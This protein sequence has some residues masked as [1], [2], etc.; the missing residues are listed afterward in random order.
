M[1]AL[2]KVKKTQLEMVR[3]RGYDISAEE[4]ILSMGPRTFIDTYMAKVGDR[5]TIRD[6][7]SN[8]YSHKNGKDRLYVHFA[9]SDPKAK[10]SLGNEPVR[11]FLSLYRDKAATTAILISELTPTSNAFF[12]LRAAGPR[13]IQHFL[14]QELISNPTKHAMVPRHQPLTPEESAEY[15]NSM[16]LDPSRPPT[17]SVAQLPLLTYLEVG[18]KPKDDF[19]QDAIVK[20]LG[21]LPGQIVRIHRTNFG[22]QTA[23]ESTIVHRVVAH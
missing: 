13:K 3:D 5:R 4:V 7:L 21:L 12:E 22:S 14:D 6:L 9:N 10:Q 15:I 8:L 16:R 18:E 17:T 19:N 20:Y 11:Y 1:D 2:L 23:V